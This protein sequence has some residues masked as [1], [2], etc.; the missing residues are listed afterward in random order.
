VE[1]T[2]PIWAVTLGGSDFWKRARGREGRGEEEDREKEKVEEKRSGWFVLD[3]LS[4]HESF[5]APSPR[6]WTQTLAVEIRRTHRRL[7]G[8]ISRET[9]GKRGGAGREAGQ[10]RALR[11]RLLPVVE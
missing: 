9:K 8:K 4:L 6:I 3:S 5:E 1:E 11:C 7:D 10:L 2:Y